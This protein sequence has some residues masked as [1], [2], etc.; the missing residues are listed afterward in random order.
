MAVD[1]DTELVLFGGVPHFCHLEECSWVVC[2]SYLMVE[3]LGG[4]D[5]WQELCHFGFVH[6]S[7]NRQYGGD[8]FEV[9]Q[10]R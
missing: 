6:V 10:R 9:F 5:F 7:R 8:F 3:D 4:V 1:E 2:D